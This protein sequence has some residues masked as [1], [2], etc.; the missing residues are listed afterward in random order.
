MNNGKIKKNE[1]IIALDYLRVIAILMIF[2]DHIGGMRFPDWIGNKLIDFVTTIPLGIIQHYGAFGVSLFFV[3]SGFLFGYNHNYENIGRKTIKRILRI[4]ILCLLSFLTFWLVQRLHWCFYETYWSQFLPKQW[5]ESAF[6]IGYFNGH[7]EVI[8]GTTW[9]LIPLFLFYL[10]TIIYAKLSER[11]GIKSIFLTEAV[12]II[13]FYL[14]YHIGNPASDYLVYVFM[15][16]S[17]LL[18][19]EM[20]KANNIQNRRDLLY[21]FTGFVLNYLTM[22]CVFYIFV[23]VYY[24]QSLYLVSYT[25]AVLLVCAF[26]LFQKAFRQNRIVSFAC[27]ISLS[28]YLIHMT[29]GSYL[30][31]IMTKNRLPITLAF[32]I[33]FVICTGIAY[34]FTKYL[35]K[36]I[37]SRLLDSLFN[38]LN[39]ANLLS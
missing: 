21:A 1:H 9:F 11:F 28:F 39:S 4:Y 25:Y 22:V 3:I 30:I 26:C 35:D 19:A 38:R 13:F 15:P 12:L 16:Y 24:S 31:T 8:N 14:L 27:E 2:Y 36:G 32:L 5:L 7:G 17:G 20:I 6:L 23:R 10:V 37:V 34:L 18:L 33:T 29:W